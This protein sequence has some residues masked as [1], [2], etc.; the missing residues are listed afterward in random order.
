MW[1]LTREAGD[2]DQTLAAHA[3]RG[4]DEEPLLASA[5]YSLRGAGGRLPGRK[6]VEH[7]F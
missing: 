7:A 5:A 6:G 1:I 3:P 4:N 2:L